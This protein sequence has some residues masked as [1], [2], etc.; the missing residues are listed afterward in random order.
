M[1]TQAEAT[2]RATEY[3]ERVDELL[4]RAENLPTL[5]QA[6][7][8]GALWAA[9]AGQ[10]PF[11]ETAPDDAGRSRTAPDETAVLE[12]PRLMREREQLIAQGADPVTLV[13][14]V[15]PFCHCL[16]RTTHVPGAFP[17]CETGKR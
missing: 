10:L 6:L 2:R 7:A 9:I 12:Y 3:A 15:S 17:D 1:I 16:G 8:A 13:M 5:E 4:A 11:V 14:P